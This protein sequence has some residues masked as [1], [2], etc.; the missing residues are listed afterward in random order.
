MSTSKPLRRSAFWWI[1]TAI[2]VRNLNGL[3][4]LHQTLAW[5]DQPAAGPSGEPLV[6]HVVVPVL[7]EQQQI[8]SALAWFV[9]LL[10]DL[11]GSTLTIVSTAREDYERRHTTTRLAG[12]TAA[13]LTAER[14]SQL[15]DEELTALSEAAA[16]G[17]LTASLAVEVL[18]R[19]PS[20]ADVIADEI[21]RLPRS[22]LRVRHVHYEGEGRKAAQV[23][24][25]VEGVAAGTREYV[26]I[27][28][29]D[30]RPSRELLYRTFDFLAHHR[31]REGELPHVIQQS[32]RFAT[33][34]A[35]S[36]WWERSL[37]RG[38]ARA[39]TLWTLRRE[40]PNLRRYASATRR[41]HAGLGVLALAQTVSHGLLVRADVFKEVGG[42]P[43]FTLLDDVAFGY[44]LTVGRI[45]VDSVPFTTTV[46]AAEFVN[47]LVAQGERWFQSYLDY[48]QC[49]SRWHAQGHGSRRDHAAALMIGA[50]RGMAWLLVSPAIATSLT[51]ALAPGTRL[52]TRAVAAAALWAA[53]VAPVHAT[54]IAQ[55]ERL[56][57]Q[58][59]AVRSAETLAGL[60]L[61]SLGPLTAVARRALIGAHGT[62]L[63]PKSNRRAAPPATGKE[64]A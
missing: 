8:A 6:L 49:A 50:Y 54:A 12:V 41:P 7:R 28:D 10:R 42:L 35:A 44:R 32:A 51:L 55:G 15:T 40:I 4:Q 27:Y 21:A 2:A 19:F 59:T 5:V 63:A 60:L 61:R 11:P 30:S 47:E 39:Q 1:A 37:C 26:A 52:P 57:A 20:T 33:L 31:D 16:D 3:R 53:T 14:F 22:A 29:V 43:T 25:A 13:D 46:P 58:E 45:P 9:P 48:R 36:T 34:G 24:A 64:P 38:A 23:N 18:A 62:A 17:P 56:T